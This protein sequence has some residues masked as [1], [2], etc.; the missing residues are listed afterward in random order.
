ML[1]KI[2]R[3]KI[4]EYVFYYYCYLGILNHKC[5]VCDLERENRADS[6]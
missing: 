1:H 5:H 6:K 2:K 3:E 4:I